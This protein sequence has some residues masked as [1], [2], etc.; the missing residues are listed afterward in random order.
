MAGADQPPQCKG[1]TIA[2][3]CIRRLAQ[4]P[5]ELAA[6]SILPYAADEEARF[7]SRRRAGVRIGTN[8]LR[9]AAVAACADATV[10]TRNMADFRQVPGMQPL[11]WS[12]P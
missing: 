10:V 5:V 4:L 3:A 9:I 1:R 11:D 7:V 2:L 6:I 12:L 8:D